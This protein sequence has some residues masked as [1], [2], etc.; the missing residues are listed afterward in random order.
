[1]KKILGIILFL[2]IFFQLGDISFVNKTYGFSLSKKTLRKVSKKEERLYKRNVKQM[3]RKLNTAERYCSGERSNASSCRR[4]VDG[5]R[6]RYDKIPLVYRIKPDVI[7][8]KKR[9]DQVAKLANQLDRGKEADRKE[10]DDFFNA[11]RAYYGEINKLSALL[12][13][14]NSGKNK[15]SFDTI[16][17]VA[18]TLSQ[19][20]NLLEKL[21]KDFKGK[22]A[23]V[24]QKNETRVNGL[25]P[26]EIYDLVKN[27][28]KYRE[29]LVKTVCEKDFKKRMNSNDSVVKMLLKEKKTTEFDLE[30]FGKDFKK[31]YKNYFKLL[32]NAY[33]RVGLKAPKW[34]HKEFEASK[35]VYNNAIKKAV[36]HN[37]WKK[38]IYSYITPALIKMSARTLKT[39]KL[40]LIDAGM[41]I[42]KWKIAKKKITGYPL[43]KWGRGR[44][45]AKKKGEPYYRM[46]KVY[47]R[48]DFDGRKYAKASSVSLQTYILPCRK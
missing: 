16:D 48:R 29:N 42:N 8:L 13:N 18:I 7:S 40:K 47:F 39:K 6:K 33:K 32:N 23:A 22:Y 27:R 31:N 14:L 45:L 19:N 35:T 4:Y 43:Y 3:E 28:M 30:Y 1:M 24:L 20:F 12:N 11:K 41:R 25:F 46:Y 34:M 5:A 9:Y 2:G 26:K 10:R 17:R 15:K 37:K 36:A 44:I 38:R 21:E